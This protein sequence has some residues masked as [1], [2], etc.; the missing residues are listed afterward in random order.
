[1]FRFFVT[2][3]GNSLMFAACLTC[4]RARVSMSG[5][6]FCSLRREF[7]EMAHVCVDFQALFSFHDAKRESCSASTTATNSH[8]WEKSGGNRAF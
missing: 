8:F 6:A 3:D 1:M 4:S 2:R 7:F 5:Q